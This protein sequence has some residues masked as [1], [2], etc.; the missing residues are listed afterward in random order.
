MTATLKCHKS[1]NRND[2]HS[3]LHDNNN[4]LHKAMMLRKYCWNHNGILGGEA[5][6]NK[7]ACCESIW[8]ISSWWER[9]FIGNG[10]CTRWLFNWALYFNQHFYGSSVEKFYHCIFVQ[11]GGVRN[12]TNHPTFATAGRHLATSKWRNWTKMWNVTVLRRRQ[13]VAK[14]K[15]KLRGRSLTTGILDE[16]RSGA[17]K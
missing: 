15:L 3:Y 6:T 8:K 9:Y 11:G 14:Q 5:I 17:S 12:T 10:Y 1:N 7:T 13:P 4:A 2:L 16:L